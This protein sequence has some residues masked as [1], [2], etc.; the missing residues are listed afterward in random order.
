MAVTVVVVAWGRGGSASEGCVRG[1]SKQV[2]ALYT[3]GLRTRCPLRSRRRPPS[4]GA[5]GRWALP[6]WGRPGR[7]ELLPA[8]GSSISYF[9][10]TLRA[11]PG[12]SVAGVA[13]GRLQRCRV[14]D[15]R[16]E[17]CS[18][19]NIPTAAGP[20]GGMNCARSRKLSSL[21]ARLGPN[22]AGAGCTS[23]AGRWG[24]GQFGHLAFQSDVNGQASRARIGLSGPKT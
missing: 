11:V 15:L 20:A 21:S 22:E 12:E 16:S 19:A 5:T 4:G 24:R 23:W 2:A 1:V 8:G 6:S 10:A 18:L 13:V 14:A 7:P 3:G 9:C 17:I